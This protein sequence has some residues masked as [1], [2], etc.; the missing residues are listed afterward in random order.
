MVP[1]TQQPQAVG[2]PSSAA[3]LPHGKLFHAVAEPRV[4]AAQSLISH[5]RKMSLEAGEWLPREI[6]LVINGVC[7][8][9]HRV[10]I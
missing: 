9:S 5:T 10:G 7:L 6:Q 3:N 8:K 4:R 2:R 1:V